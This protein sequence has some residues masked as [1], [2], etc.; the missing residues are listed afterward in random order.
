VFHV[1]GGGGLAGVKADATA[2]GA[3]VN[4]C[5]RAGEWTAAMR[6]LDRMEYEGI[7]PTPQ[8]G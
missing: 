8:V 6:L 2:F 3:A 5:A 7:K 4:A 1:D